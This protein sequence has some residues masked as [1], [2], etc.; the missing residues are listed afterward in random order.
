M[1]P[2]QTITLQRHLVE[3]LAGRAPSAGAAGP[4]LEFDDDTQ[5]EVVGTWVA[6]EVGIVTLSTG[7]AGLLLRIG[8][9]LEFGVFRVSRDVFYVPGLD[10]WM[11]FGGATRPTAMHLKSMFVEATLGRAP[12]DAEPLACK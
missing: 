3:V 7:G 12:D 4:F 5:L 9:G 8:C 11:A 6:E 2:W 10:Y 1:P